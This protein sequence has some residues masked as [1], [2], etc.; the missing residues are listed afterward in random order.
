M[1]YILYLLSILLLISI[2]FN[3]RLY[4]GKPSETVII[5]DSINISEFIDTVYYRDTL[6]VVEDTVYILKEY[7]KTTVY[8]PT[9]RIPGLTGRDSELKF[10]IG[11]SENKIQWLNYTGEFHIPKHRIGLL[12]TLNKKGMYT[13]SY[14]YTFQK[15]NNI[16][17][18]GNINYIPSESKVIPSVGIGIRF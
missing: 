18:L 6:P 8:N 15:N 13:I 16:E 1:K 11:V 4:N 14:G 12:R 2:F 10:D 7:F 9:I 3:Y 17:I 5:K